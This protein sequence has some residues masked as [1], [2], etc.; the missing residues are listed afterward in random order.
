MRC[1]KIFSKYDCERIQHAFAKYDIVDEYEQKLIELL[2]NQ[3]QRAKQVDPKKIKSNVVTMNSKF[4]LTNLGNGKKEEYHL[5]FPDESD[6][7][8]KKISLIS[9]IGAQVIGSSIGTVIKGNSGSE[10]YF[11]IESIIYQPE[12]AGHFNL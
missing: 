1:D 10:Q 4:V 6:A 8:N 11:M 3:L 9:G 5:V 2:K 7:N 12:A